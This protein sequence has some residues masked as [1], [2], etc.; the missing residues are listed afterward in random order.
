M[1]Y[2]VDAIFRHVMTHQRRAGAEGGLALAVS[3]DRRR[4]SAAK[5]KNSREKK[6]E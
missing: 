6:S 3:S 2:P 1:I 5:E 4:R